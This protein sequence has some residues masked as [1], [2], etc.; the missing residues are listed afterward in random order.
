MAKY[1][2]SH[3]L[4]RKIMD[5]DRAEKAALKMIRFELKKVGDPDTAKR[6]PD[7]YIYRHNDDYSKS[8]T[9]DTRDW[10]SYTY[11]LSEKEIIFE[12]RIP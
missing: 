10:K 9:I 7:L 2:V 1:R 6:M 4:D 8:F 12:M 3:A 11:Y 5:D